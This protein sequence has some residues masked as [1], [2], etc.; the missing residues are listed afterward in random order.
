M[1]NTPGAVPGDPHLSHWSQAQ[2]LVSPSLYWG[3]TRNTPTRSACPMAPALPL[4]ACLPGTQRGLCAL[5]PVGPSPHT[6][7]GLYQAPLGTVGS[8]VVTRG[9]CL[10]LFIFLEW[11]IDLLLIS[12]PRDI[13]CPRPL[14]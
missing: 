6:H 2:P 10:L 7:A 1:A 5:A 13:L 9:T 8:L 14:L 12:F 11:V 3:V 4:T